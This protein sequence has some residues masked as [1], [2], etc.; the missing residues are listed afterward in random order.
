MF[1]LEEEEAAV[2]SFRSLA[3]EMDRL[4][5]WWWTDL[6]KKVLARAIVLAP[7]NTAYRRLFTELV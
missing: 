7:D 3:I 6:A 2:R 5:R 4:L 1:T